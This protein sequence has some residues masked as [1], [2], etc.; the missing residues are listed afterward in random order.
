MRPEQLNPY[1]ARLEN[2]P[3]IGP[4]T[5]GHLAR[6]V[7][8]GDQPARA[9][10]LLFHFPTGVVDRRDRP[11]LADA[12]P[13][14]TVTLA[15]RA[16]EHRPP[17][18]RSRQP[19]R[20]Y[21]ED[22][23]D[24]VT[25]V[26]FHAHAAHMAKL[27]P[28]GETR[29]VSGRLDLWN[30]SKQIVHPDHVVDATE[31]E[32]LPAL[33]PI[34]PLVAGITNRMLLRAFEP[35]LAR[36]PELPEWHDPEILRRHGWSSFKQACVRLH[37]PCEIRDVDPSGLPWSRLAFDEMLSSQLALK[38]VRARLRRAQG[39]S[40]ADEGRLAA[41][42]E[43]AL[44][45]SLTASQAQSIREIRS[46]MAGPQRMLRLLQGDVGSGKTVVA[47]LAMACAVEAGAQAALMAPTELLVRQHFQTIEKLAPTVGLRVA[48]LT[49]SERGGERERTLD[50]L[51]RGEID[52]LVGTHALFQSGV[53]FA[54]LGLAVIDEQHR[55]GV[56]QRLA[57][58]S[59]SRGGVADLLVMTATPIPR[60]LVLTFFGDMDVSKLTEKPAGRQPIETRLVAL[61]RLD[62]LVTAL[63]RRIAE[64]AQAYWVCPLVEE[65]DTLD[66]TS[67]EERFRVLQM[68]FGPRA[69]LVHGRM[70]GREK[71]E[72]MR[73]FR[74]GEISVLVATTVIEV[75]VD[76]P[77]ASIM[78]IEN[79]ERFGLAQLHQLRGRVGRGSAKSS[80]VLLYRK[81]L[82]ATAQARLRTMRDTE[83]GFVIAEEDLRLRGAGEILGTRQ[84]GT[85]LFN[86]ARLEHHEP[87]LEMAQKDAERVLLA[88][89][90]L[91]GER[92]RALRTL[93]YLFE[94][95]DAV[96]LIGAG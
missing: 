31:F 64:G 11:R 29:Y 40:H 57:L 35:L 63:E 49:G 84:S 87:L 73:R 91:Q 10:D 28:V 18:G 15:L 76:V 21:C 71:D 12:L 9:I 20:V 30:G 27:L 62:E 50:A 41:R 93:L 5:A 86:I 82:G 43:A 24:G 1:F 88:D 79:A 23:S 53:E 83:D 17:P 33:E 59:K 89:P 56:H 92:G 69:A 95:D 96:R 7:G 47:L 75:G 80:C 39:I 77:N 44:P 4:R 85:P 65:S 37:R 45:F 72:V 81:P 32:K 90:Y 36:L 38:L 61:D 74:A 48:I 34:Y 16:V 94:R 70:S 55:F 2:L 78:V 67:A 13:G 26:F 60:T 14:R 46:D 54:N 25:L 3:G 6:L 22:D 42:I 19:Y 68:R 52:I 51:A 58:S 8:D 66:A